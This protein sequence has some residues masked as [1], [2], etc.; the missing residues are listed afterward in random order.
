[1]SRAEEIVSPF[2]KIFESFDFLRLGIVVC[3][4]YGRIVYANTSV[5]LLCGQSLKHLRE[6]K[7][8]QCLNAS[9]Q[10][11]ENYRE[12]SEP[13]FAVF[14]ELDYFI[15]VPGEEIPVLVTV[16]PFVEDPEYLIVELVSA[17][18]TLQMARERHMNEL[19]ENTRR[20]LRNLAHEIKNPLGGIRGAAQLLEAELHNSENKEYTEV[21]IS[22]A[23]RL[24]LL[25]DKILAPYRQLYHPVPTNVHEI[26]ERVR[27]LVQSEFPIGL[28]IVRDYDI[29]APELMADRGQL[30]Q[31]FLNLMR[32]AAEALSEQ[33]AAGR[34]Q[35]IL[36]TR[37]SHHL[38]VGKKLCRTVL[39]IH[40]SDNGEGIP[41]ELI[42]SIFYPLVS[43]KEQGSG[44]GLSLVQTF[45]EQHGGTITVTSQPGKT[46][47]NILFPLSL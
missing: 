32:N 39:N 37:V 38:Y 2:E 13:S 42:D 29:S 36:K 30:T 14:N 1:M 46:D 3:T 21:I 6:R 31:I 22:E 45:V 47:F 34:A 5:Q 11:L 44:L 7:L 23:D 20:L 43:G 35:I 8:Q 26:L 9:E 40:V 18:R 27:L 24:Q 33:M 15:K 4:K 19:S 28:K 10:W 41:Q 17:D 16:H 25:V 12:H